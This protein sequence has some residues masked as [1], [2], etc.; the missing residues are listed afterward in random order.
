MPTK[1]QPKRHVDVP[2]PSI[3]LSTAAKSALCRLLH[4]NG[5]SNDK[6]MAEL[7]ET[8]A[9]AQKTIREGKV[10]PLPPHIVAEVKPILACARKLHESI[11]SASVHAQGSMPS[12]SELLDALSA[13]EFQTGVSV[14]QMEGRPKLGGGGKRRAIRQHRD[15]SEHGLGVFWDLHANVKDAPKEWRHAPRD[16]SHGYWFCADR[17]KFIEGCMDII[18]GL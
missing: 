15:V 3:Q 5:P 1:T 16:P 17:Q 4:L 12:S 7:E 8:L 11:R 14:M 2:L 10:R 6:A 13:F 9:W 18:D